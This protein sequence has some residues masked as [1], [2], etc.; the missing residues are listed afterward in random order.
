MRGCFN[1]AHFTHRAKTALHTLASWLVT[2]NRVIATFAPIVNGEDFTS[3]QVRRA[4]APDS[5]GGKSSA[6]LQHRRRSHAKIHFVS[7][8]E[9]TE[10]IEDELLVGLRT[11]LDEVSSGNAVTPRDKIEMCSVR[12]SVAFRVLANTQLNL[13]P[14]RI[15][16]PDGL[17]ASKSHPSHDCL[18]LYSLVPDKSLKHVSTVTEDDSVRGLKDRA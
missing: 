1:R 15:E 3:R 4:L 5:K 13:T 14:A 16:M 12:Y 9:K 8:G 7:N 17:P 18:F 2:R 6:R 11:V 10:P